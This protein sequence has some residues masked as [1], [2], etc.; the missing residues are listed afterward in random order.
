VDVVGTKSDMLTALCNGIDSDRVDSGLYRSAFFVNDTGSFSQAFIA[1]MLRALIEAV[2]ENDIEAQ[3]KVYAVI[4]QIGDMRRGDNSVRRAPELDRFMPY[5][6]RIFGMNNR[7]RGHRDMA[8]MMFHSLFTSI[9]FD[10]KKCFVDM[11]S[12]L[13]RYDDLLASREDFSKAM[14]SSLSA[15]TDTQGKQIFL[16]KEIK[17]E[18]SEE[19]RSFERYRRKILD[20]VRDNTVFAD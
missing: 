12:R 7:T 19:A 14:R 11:M 6:E 20:G 1:G 16:F 10:R 9:V 15:I 3:R 4:K 18:L 8:T 2:E 17:Q 13:E 5:M